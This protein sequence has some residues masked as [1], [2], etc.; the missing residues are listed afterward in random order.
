MKQRFVVMLLCEGIEDK[1][2]KAYGKIKVTKCVL[3]ILV[4][5]VGIRHN[6]FVY[7]YYIISSS[8]SLCPSIKRLNLLLV[9]LVSNH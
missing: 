7:V 8:F 4:V 9:E 5:R 1:F 3:Q 6:L 2:N